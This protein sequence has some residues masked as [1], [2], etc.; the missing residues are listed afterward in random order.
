MENAV[1]TNGMKSSEEIGMAKQ[2][3]INNRFARYI[4]RVRNMEVENRERLLK[5][6]EERLAEQHEIHS[7]R[8]QE[9]REKY[10]RQMKI[11][12]EEIEAIY[13]AKIQAVQNAAQ[14]DKSTLA[15]ALAELKNTQDR[16]DKVNEK[17]AIVEQVNLSLHNRIDDLKSALENERSRVVSGV[18][19]IDRLRGEIE[20][21]LEEHQIMLQAKQGLANEILLYDKLLTDAENPPNRKRKI[22]KVYN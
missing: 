10:E 11:N 9:L 2:E 8:I 4:D 21:R 14:K 5:E 6:A 17:I 1:Q 19:E 7:N 13:E 15:D 16:N 22:S 3:S 12:R 20:L 18:N